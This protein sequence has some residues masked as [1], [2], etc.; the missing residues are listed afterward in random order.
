MTPTKPVAVAALR[1]LLYAAVAA[2]VAVVIAA[3][4][5]DLADFGPAAPVILWVA[6]I[7]EAWLLDRRQPRQLG[8]LGGKGSA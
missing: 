1:G 8:A 6:R 4:P 7:A 5:A 2:I 3:S